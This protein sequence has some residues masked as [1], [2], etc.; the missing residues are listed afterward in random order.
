MKISPDI[1]SAVIDAFTARGFQYQSRSQDGRY[2]L[3]GSLNTSEGAHRCEIRIKSDFS[4]PPVVR[5]LDIPEK[6]KPVAPHIDSQGGIC[7]LS[8]SSVSINIF[9]PVGQM[10]GC[11]ER[12]EFVLGQIL[13]D[14]AVNDLAEEFFAFWGNSYSFCYFDFKDINSK[15]LK[16]MYGNYKKALMIFVVTDDVERSKTKI[17]SLIYEVNE[18]FLPVIKIFT[19]VS[20][21]P[22]QGNWPPSNLSELLAWQSVIDMRTSRRI[23]E[24]LSVAAEK[25]KRIAIVLIQSPNYVYAF[26]VFFTKNGDAHYDKK[27]LRKKSIILRSEVMP[28]NGI[29]IDENYIIQRNVPGM[30]TLQGKKIALIGCGTI[31]GYLADM[32]VK[33]GAGAGEGEFVL[34]DYDNLSA[35]NIG[36][37]RL[38][39]PY[40]EK[41]KAESLCREL[42]ASLP[43]ANLRGVTVDVRKSNLGKFDFIVNATGEQ[44]VADYLAISYNAIP[45]LSAWIEGPGVAV[46]ALLHPKMESACYHCL[47]MHNLDGN[48]NSTVRPIPQLF[49]GQGC[50]QE[51][52]PF[53]ATVSIHAAC[54]A[55]EL[56]LD[57]VNDNA[58]KTLRT[59]VLNS[60]FEIATVDCTLDKRTDCPA[61]NT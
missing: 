3:T 52:V 49:S 51:Y 31:G 48:Y 45:Q 12:V 13:R 42:G 7:Y 56:A 23:Y 8:K 36:R 25:G 57:W 27:E 59:R 38:G 10:L 19:R 24:Q 9:D 46:R 30:K 18:V 44:V 55:C 21:R 15:N 39:F 14:E 41:N 11:L 40:V 22:L 20:P 43:D 1:S 37:H 28:M 35:A 29:R 4:A 54:L 16:C 50:E 60:E 58:T 6:L 17:A 34:F 61:C 33:A 32:L 26:S 53:P 2:V 5:L 47:T